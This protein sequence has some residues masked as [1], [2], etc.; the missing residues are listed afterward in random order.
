MNLLY[1]AAGD[2]NANIRNEALKLLALR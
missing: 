1:D 2:L